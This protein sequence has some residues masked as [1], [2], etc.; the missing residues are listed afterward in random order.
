[1]TNGKWFDI[2]KKDN[3]FLELFDNDNNYVYI[4]PLTV[5][6]IVTIGFLVWYI[7]ELEKE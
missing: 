5:I 7:K 6:P 3:S 4:T 1:M 2:I